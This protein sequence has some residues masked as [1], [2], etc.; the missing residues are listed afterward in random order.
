MNRHCFGP[1]SDFLRQLLFFFNGSNKV[2]FIVLV[3][4][5]RLLLKFF[6]ESGKYYEQFIQ[7]Q[8]SI[9][10]H[11]YPLQVSGASFYC[12]PFSLFSFFFSFRLLGLV[13][14]VFAVSVFFLTCE[15]PRSFLVPWP[16]INFLLHVA[17]DS[18]YASYFQIVLLGLS[19]PNSMNGLQWLLLS[20]N[21]EICSL[22]GLWWSSF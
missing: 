3:E 18:A 9:S 19:Y 20:I 11:L 7:R 21:M 12:W 4:S 14:V 17:N 5:C 22:V 13:L 2:D 16:L 6:Q 8:F 15:P 1:D 10:I